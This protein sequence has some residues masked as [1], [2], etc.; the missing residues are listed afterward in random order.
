[1]INIT[2]SW[3][4]VWYSKYLRGTIEGDGTIDKIY[5]N[6]HT[7]QVRLYSDEDLD[8]ERLSIN[9]SEPI[10]CATGDAESWRI[11]LFQS[12]GDFVKCFSCFAT[13][14]PGLVEAVDEEHLVSPLGMRSDVGLCEPACRGPLGL[15]AQGA[16]FLLKLSR[17]SG[18]GFA[19]KHV[20]RHVPKC[21]QRLWSHDADAR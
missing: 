5:K 14:G 6:S 2:V 3:R 16:A 17:L 12:R 18:T 4:S 10:G 15:I 21:A 19:E 11:E 13:A 7:G 20:G 8:G 1:M 9:R